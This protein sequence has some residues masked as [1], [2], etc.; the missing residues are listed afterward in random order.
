MPHGGLKF[1]ADNLGPHIVTPRIRRFLRILTLNERENRRRTVT[2]SRAAVCINPAP[3]WQRRFGLVELLHHPDDDVVITIR[4]YFCSRM[5]SH[6]ALVHVAA[7]IK[8]TSTTRLK[9]SR[10]I[11]AKLLSREM[12]GL[13]TNW[14]IRAHRSVGCRTSLER[15]R[16]LFRFHPRRVAPPRWRDRRRHGTSAGEIRRVGPAQPP[17]PVTMAIYPLSDIK[18]DVVHV[19]PFDI[20]AKTPQP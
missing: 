6:T 20:S 1:R 4:P 14:S 8:C 15:C 17:A 2:S 13:F 10:F 11:L 5:I 3:S 12:P 18:G 9:S 16:R 19:M 7:P